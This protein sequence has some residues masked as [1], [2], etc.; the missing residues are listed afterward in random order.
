MEK[1]GQ[2]LSERIIEN[3]LKNGIFC[4]HPERLWNER[5]ILWGYFV[6]CVC[7]IGLTQ[8]TTN[9]VA[10]NRCTITNIVCTIS[11]YTI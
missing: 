1:W 5:S 9:Q 2:E 4:I 8:L 11:F 3:P 10:T 6:L 7:V